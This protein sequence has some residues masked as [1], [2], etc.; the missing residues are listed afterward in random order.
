MDAKVCSS[1]IVGIGAL[2]VSIEVEARKAIRLCLFP[3]W[4]PPNEEQP[5]SGFRRPHE[6][7]VRVFV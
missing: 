7:T 6:I 1:V 2:A 4:N 5:E 3:S